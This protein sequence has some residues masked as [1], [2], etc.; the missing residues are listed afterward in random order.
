MS[1][2]LDELQ[3]L[4]MERDRAAFV[5]FRD[6]LDLG[7]CIVREPLQQENSLVIRSRLPTAPRRL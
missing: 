1:D 3:V 6:E 2:T 4:R 7:V 5:Y